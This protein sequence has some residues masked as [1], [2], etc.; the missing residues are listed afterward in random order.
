MWPTPHPPHCP[1]LAPQTT[2]FLGGVSQFGNFALAEYLRTL[3]LLL[4]RERG[5]MPSRLRFLL[6]DTLLRV[7]VPVLDAH[8]RMAP[9][10][11]EG[12]TAGTGEDSYSTA[13]GAGGAGVQAWAAVGP[14]AAQDPTLAHAGQGG[15][16]AASIWAT[17]PM[18]GASP[19]CGSAATALRGPPPADA[20]HAPVQPGRVDP[21]AIQD[22]VAA[23]AAAAA[24]AR[25]GG[26]G[27][28]PGAASPPSLS[29][30]GDALAPHESPLHAATPPL[31]PRAKPLPLAGGVQ[32]MVSPAEAEEEG[33]SEEGEEGS[34]GAGGAHWGRALQF[35]PRAMDTRRASDRSRSLG[36]GGASLAAPPSRGSFVMHADGGMR[37]HGSPSAGSHGPPQIGVDDGADTGQRARKDVSRR[38]HT[39][40]L[41]YFATGNVR[42]LAASLTAPE[43]LPHHSEVVVRACHLALERGALERNLLFGML[44]LLAAP[45]RP[46][47]ETLSGSEEEEEEEEGEGGGGAESSSSARPASETELSEGAEPGPQSATPRSRAWFPS[48]SHARGESQAA[49]PD[50]AAAVHTRGAGGSSILPPHPPPRR[51]GGHAASFDAT[52]AGVGSNAATPP[53]AHDSSHTARARPQTPTLVG[54]DGSQL[55]YAAPL[56]HPTASVTPPPGGARRRNR[57]RARTSSFEVTE[58]AVAPRSTTTTLLFGNEAPAMRCRE[59]VTAFV[60][61][62]DACPGTGGTHRTRSRRS[63][64]RPNAATATDADSRGR[65]R[66][67]SSRA[68]TGE[69]AGEEPGRGGG[70]A[71]AV[72]DDP[73]RG[74][75]ARPRA[76][77]GGACDVLHLVSEKQSPPAA[78][79]D[80]APRLALH[81]AQGYAAAQDAGTRAFVRGLLLVQHVARG[82]MPAEAAL[83]DNAWLRS[84][85]AARSSPPLP[86]GAHAR[87]RT[88]S[89]PNQVAVGGRAGFGRARS[90]STS[91]ADVAPMFVV[92]YRVR[93]QEAHRA[94]AH[95]ARD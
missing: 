54:S 12:G 11:S 92:E 84:A 80:G 60:G 57:S 56:L 47:V 10:P 35:G 24:A 5:T 73:A 61:G 58:T 40:L 39:V 95:C 68:G 94:G 93:L 37:L 72:A 30:S 44:V 26:G 83:R 29:R 41:D 90:H 42:E 75:G 87:V 74:L 79:G 77:G 4:A 7:G 48:A 45:P 20:A 19:G 15:A 38:I 2:P 27:G 21:W 78:A 63:D 59:R 71:P 14:T 33:E 49:T 13:A 3:C 69:E 86:P 46:E 9:A 28:G 70:A 1:P 89:T 52:A 8:V 81:A 50:P 53:L 65:A 67:T 91:G 25:R 51:S 18:D 55:G 17:G 43:I 64:P 85:A 23:A 16:P 88:A 31:R 32:P 22:A 66:G 62:E 82:G 34:T 76:V 6:E 36:S